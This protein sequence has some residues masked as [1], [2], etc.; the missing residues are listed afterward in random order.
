MDPEGGYLFDAGSGGGTFTLEGRDS[1]YTSK[2]SFLF[3]NKQPLLSFIWEKGSPYKTG[4]YTIE[5]FSEG[6]KLGQSNF[7]VK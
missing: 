5:L 3:D 1:P 6:I 4:T 7:I 2:L